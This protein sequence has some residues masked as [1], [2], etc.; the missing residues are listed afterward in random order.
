[1]EIKGQMPIPCYR[2]VKTEIITRATKESYSLPDPLQLLR[3]RE[4]LSEP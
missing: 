4:S 1:M 3:R 2:V